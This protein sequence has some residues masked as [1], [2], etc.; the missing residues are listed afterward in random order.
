MR[1]L[2]AVGCEAV[3]KHIFGH[4]SNYV[5]EETDHR[6]WLERVEVSEHAGNS[7][8]YEGWCV[9]LGQVAVQFHSEGNAAL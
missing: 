3:A 6:V 5:R 4:V 2:P 7:A 1:V 8:I 9:S